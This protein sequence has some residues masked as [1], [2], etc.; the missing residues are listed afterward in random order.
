MHQK[1]LSI[2]KILHSQTSK[3][4]N[5]FRTNVLFCNATCLFFCFWHYNSHRL[6]PLKILVLAYKKKSKKSSKRRSR[7]KND[8]VWSSLLWE[9]TLHT[10]WY[11]N[12]LHHGRWCIS[13][14]AGCISSNSNVPYI[15]P[16]ITTGL[17]T[18]SH[19]VAVPYLN[20]NAFYSEANRIL[21]IHK[22]ESRK[23]VH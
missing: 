7:E 10:I 2:C 16:I 13:N 18:A 8:Q 19:A 6:H 3:R 21:C 12:S 15:T 9:N 1:V 14:D 22:N 11:R 4:M 5:K 23:Q 17:P 20:P